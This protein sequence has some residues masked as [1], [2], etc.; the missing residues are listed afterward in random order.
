MP[1]T[2][3]GAIVARNNIAL[4]VRTRQDRTSMSH[5]L[6]TE[7]FFYPTVL[8]SKDLKGLP[9]DGEFAKISQITFIQKLHC[10]FA[11]A[12]LSTTAVLAC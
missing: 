8:T 9:H 1:D 5:A 7:L 6:T 10:E 12:V 2:S 3:F 11:I 4:T